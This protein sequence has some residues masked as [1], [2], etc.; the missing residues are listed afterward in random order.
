MLERRRL[1]V[2][3]AGG[4]GRAVAE[5]AVLAGPFD[6]LGFLDDGLV[7]GSQVMNLPVLGSTG[8]DIRLLAEDA[9]VIVAIGNNRLRE[10]LM[11]SYRERGVRLASVVHPAAYVS[12]SAIVGEGTVIMA[13]AVVGT[14]G[15]IGAG[16]IVNCGCIV[17]HDCV[18]EDFAHLGV[19]VS[20]AG[21]VV[22]GRSAW[23]QAGS[24]AGYGVRVAAGEAL[25][26]GTA[27]QL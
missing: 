7:A 15:R 20:L 19:G 9:E 18:L 5:A 24:A 14:L 2:V 11:T 16:A 25:P 3:G 13:G 4:H 12:V 26:P 23:L 10:K 17:D 21:G 1:V 22:I 6:V 27:L 8:S